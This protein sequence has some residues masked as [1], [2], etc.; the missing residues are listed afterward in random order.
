MG[1][2]YGDRRFAMPPGP[3][4]LTKRPGQELLRYGSN[5]LISTDHPCQS[6]RNLHDCSCSDSFGLSRRLL[7]ACDR[8]TSNNTTGKRSICSEPILSTERF[9]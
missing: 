3:T 5:G 6:W 2:G 1:D 4:M 8:R 9:P 7:R